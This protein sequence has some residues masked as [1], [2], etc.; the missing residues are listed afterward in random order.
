MVFCWQAGS[1]NADL[2]QMVISWD[3][4]THGLRVFTFKISE[5]HFLC[6]LMCIRKL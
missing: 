2:I 4:Q 1:E 5:I 3:K 6:G